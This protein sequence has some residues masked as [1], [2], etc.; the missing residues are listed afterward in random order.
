[1]DDRDSP[2]TLALPEQESLAD[3]L[4]GFT[5]DAR[6]YASAEF[7]YQKSRATYAGKQALIAAGLAGA[8]LVFLFFALEAL[9]FG[10]IIV[11]APSLTPLGA[12]AAVTGSLVAAALLLFA[13]AM[14]RWRR[15]K[16]KI[17]EQDD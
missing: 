13:L 17:A 6:A 4:R 16:A 3:E 7:A 15:M 8:A 1:M 2:A 11:L 10:A 5:E 12:T 9:V 14:F